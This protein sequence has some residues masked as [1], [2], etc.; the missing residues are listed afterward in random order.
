MSKV[1]YQLYQPC[2]LFNQITS[3]ESA[4]GIAKKYNKELIVHNITNPPDK[5]YGNKSVPIY[6]ANYAFNDRKGLIESNVFPKISD[7]LDWE[8]KENHVL[9]DNSVNHFLD[10]GLKIENVMKYY[11]VDSDSVSNKED[12]FAEGRTRL[13][14]NNYENIHLGKTLGYY[15]RFF[16]NRDKAL[17]TTLFSVRFKPEY[18]QLAKQIAESL[19]N[20]NGAHFRLTDHK[21][22]FD[23]N[24]SILDEGISRIDNGLPIVLCTDQSKSEIIIKSSYSYILL[25]DYILN[26][27]HKDF[28]Q[29]KFK[30]EVS[31]GILNNLVMHYS[32]NFIG[33]PGSTYTGYIHRGINQKRDIQWNIFGEEEH[34]QNGP[35]SWNGYESKDTM[36]KQW[37]REWKESRLVI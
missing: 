31:F 19:G 18:Y 25:D 4:V 6:S 33:S 17:D 2:G 12:A 34:I 23:P 28:M 1:F 35:Y 8:N 30:E 15:S 3:I 9:I 27:F 20:F 16:L 5:N 13:N 29:F 32:N 10:E 36:T 22:M 7:L 26:N 24:N 37:W 21:K 11:L 14:L